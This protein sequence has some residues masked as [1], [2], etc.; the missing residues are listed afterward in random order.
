MKPGD[1]L[2]VHMAWTLP[3]GRRLRATFQAEVLALDPAAD[4]WHGRLIEIL[5]L[6]P[7]LADEWTERVYCQVGKRVLFPN[8]ATTGMVLPLKVGTLTGQIR[9][10]LENKENT[11]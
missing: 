8:E 4:R 10:F 9:Y 3:D 2:P 5:H 1:R 7:A 6:D 11:S